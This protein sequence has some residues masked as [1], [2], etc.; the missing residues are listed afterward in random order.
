[1][2]QGRAHDGDSLQQVEAQVQLHQAGHIEGVGGDAFV[3]EVVVRHPDV[4]QLGQTGQEALRQRVDGVVLHVEL[5]QLFRERLRDLRKYWRFVEER[6][7][8]TQTSEPLQADDDLCQLVAADVQHREG[9]QGLQGGPHV[10][11]GI[12]MEVQE[13]EVVHSFQVCDCHLG[14]MGKQFQRAPAC[15][16]HQTLP[17]QSCCDL[18]SGLS[19]CEGGLQECWSGYCVGGT[20]ALAPPASEKPEKYRNIKK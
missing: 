2:L 6:G 1:M 5:V 8:F 19:G 14:S 13:G 3:C 15:T 17:F 9:F 16:D 11:D 20:N 18:F 12:V 7:S 4:L 10:C